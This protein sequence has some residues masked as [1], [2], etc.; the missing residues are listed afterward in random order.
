MIAGVAAAAVVFRTGDRID[1]GPEG[2]RSAAVAPATAAAR[3]PWGIYQIH[4]RDGQFASG[5]DEQLAQLGGTPSY[6]LDFR[7]LSAERSFPVGMATAAAGRGLVPIISVELWRWS[8]HREAGGLEAVAAG[9]YDA[10]F[11]RWAREAAAFGKPL[12]LRFGFEMNGDWFPWGRKPE[13]FKSAWRRVHALFDD[14][15]AV[16]VRWM[17]AP[18]VLY[19]DLT[20]R[21]GIEDYWPGDDAVDLVGLDGYN[22]GDRHDQW[23]RWQSYREVFEAS[24]A[25]LSLHRK[26]LVIS[27]IACADDP[28]KAAWVRD[29]LAAVGA[30]ARVSGF[31]WFNLDKRREHE[32]DWRLESDEQTL[33]AFRS[34]AAPRR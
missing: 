9:G 16:N 2:P 20:P 12:V 24:V 13:L 27:E 17:F 6:V 11:A 34:W 26:P 28:R 7:D 23:H 18:N 33:D 8:R 22:F 29:F 14:A 32:P 31:V 10:F 3:K 1:D 30:D 21:T 25:A 5:L 4:W 19:G 15:R